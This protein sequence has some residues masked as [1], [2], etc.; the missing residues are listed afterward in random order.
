MAVNVVTD[1]PAC[2]IRVHARVRGVV[3]EDDTVAIVLVQCPS[4]G[5]PIVGRSE[6]YEDEMLDM[7]YGH[8]ERVWPAPS[9]VELNTSIPERARREIKDAQKGLSH[10]MYPA[11]V[12]HC[13]RAVELLVENKA[14][15]KNTLA[16]GLLELKSKGV[17]DDR[18]YQW[19]TALRRERNL[20]AHAGDHEVTKEDAT[21]V[22]AFTIA[23]FEYI[24]T[25]TEK[26]DEYMARKK[27]PK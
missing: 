21:D 8:A 6:L 9:T 25:L 5:N 10:G 1:C 13:G 17:I 20:G 12:V 15:G 2:N 26:Y 16:N 24:Y 19:A 22:L 4:C 23:I 14:P 3:Y 7:Q 18:L 27:A 11:A